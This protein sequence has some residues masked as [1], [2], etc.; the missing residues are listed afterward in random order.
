MKEKLVAALYT[1]SLRRVSVL[2][3]FVFDNL[4]IYTGSDTERI[5]LRGCKC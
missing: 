1:F 2:G 3:I 4:V 5:S